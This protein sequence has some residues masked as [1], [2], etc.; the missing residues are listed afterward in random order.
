M[1]IKEATEIA[2]GGDVVPTCP[3]PDEIAMLEA[4]LLEERKRFFAREDY[5]TT[6]NTRLKTENALLRELVRPT[7]TRRDLFAAALV[8]GSCSAGLERHMYPPTKMLKD[9]D[10]IIAALNA[11][12]P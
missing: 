7:I 1:T 6:E 10:T 8:I 2:Y 11:P 3:K 4:A 12:K 9:I 5:L